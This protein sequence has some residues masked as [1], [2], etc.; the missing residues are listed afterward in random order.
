[1]QCMQL[2]TLDTSP[3]PPVTAPTAPVATVC[4]DQTY[5]HNRQDTSVLAIH[6]HASTTVQVY[7]LL[8][9]CIGLP[10]PP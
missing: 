9:I 3:A 1:M 8:L 4:I 10:I 2:L 7:C 5:K 6:T